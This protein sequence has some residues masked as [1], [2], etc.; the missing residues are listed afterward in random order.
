MPGFLTLLLDFVFRKESVYAEFVS[1][2]IL[3]VLAYQ[4][5]D[6]FM[7]EKASSVMLTAIG[8]MQLCSL[9]MW[10]CRQCFSTRIFTAA[11]GSFAWLVVSSHQFERLK[12]FEGAAVATLMGSLI[13]AA[14][15]M[16]AALNMI[17]IR[18][19]ESQDTGI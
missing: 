16:M 3:L 13:L 6:Y 17:N 14:T 11:A 9:M 15:M 7:S 19:Q 8:V 5:R 1:G 12:G 10:R 2:V 18:Q 4:S